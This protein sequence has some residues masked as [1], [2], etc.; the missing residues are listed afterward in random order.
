VHTAEH[1][2]WHGPT[3]SI[4]ESCLARHYLDRAELGSGRACAGGPFGHL[5]IRMQLL[6]PASIYM[7]NTWRIRARCVGRRRM[8]LI[9]MHLIMF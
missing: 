6:L 2:G 9:I 8:D 1:V 3:R 4:N 5:Y 7:S